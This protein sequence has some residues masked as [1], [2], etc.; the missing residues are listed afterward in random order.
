MDN[1]CLISSS[2]QLCLQKV[3][4]AHLSTCGFAI[5]MYTNV[6]V[7]FVRCIECISCSLYVEIVEAPQESDFSKEYWPTVEDAYEAAVHSIHSSTSLKHIWKQLSFYHCTLIACIFVK[8]PCAVYTMHLYLHVFMYSRYLLYLKNYATD[9]N[10]G[11]SSW[12]V[13]L[14]LYVTWR[15]ALLNFVF[16]CSN[17]WMA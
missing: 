12:K 11:Q 2:H 6:A 3:I 8:Y 10:A 16:H 1:Q 13:N 5:G 7:L 9:Q 15:L 4:H 17:F 14:Y